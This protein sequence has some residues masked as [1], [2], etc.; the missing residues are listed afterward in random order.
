MNSI[1][2]LYDIC[3]AYI[4][5]VSEYAIHHQ[6]DTFDILFPNGT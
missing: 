2:E 3:R 5:G 1:H 4:F 6:A